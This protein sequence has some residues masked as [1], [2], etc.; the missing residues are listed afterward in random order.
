MAVAI[1]TTN[2]GPGHEPAFVD[3][4]GDG[5][6]VDG[7]PVARPAGAR[8]KFGLRGKQRFAAADAGVC[9]GLF[10][11]IVGMGVGCLGA[12]LAGD[13]VLFRRELGT[14][15]GFR[16]GYFGRDFGVAHIESVFRSDY[17]DPNNGDGARDRPAQ[18]TKMTRILLAHFVRGFASD[19]ILAFGLRPDET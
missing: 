8:V 1:G 18:A 12:V 19:A 16:L 7:G 15:F 2:L 17:L 4:L 9:A 14:P 6:L 11:G 13:V 5:L 10:I 3:V